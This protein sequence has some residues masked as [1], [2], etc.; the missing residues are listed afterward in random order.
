MAAGLILTLPALFLT[1]AF[2]PKPYLPGLSA[3]RAFQTATRH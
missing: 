1:S 2:F 3:V